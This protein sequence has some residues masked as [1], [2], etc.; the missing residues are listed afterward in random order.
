MPNLSSTS[1][2]F[3]VAETLT[4]DVGRAVARLDPDDMRTQGL[5]IGD[6]VEVAGK[7]RTLCKVLPAHKEARGQTQV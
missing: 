6:F 1:L 7:S 5:E 4:R 3:K 2:R